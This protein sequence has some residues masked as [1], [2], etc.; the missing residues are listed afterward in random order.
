MSMQF[1][2]LHESGSGTKP[3]ID[4]VCFRC[5]FLEASRTFSRMALKAESDP[6][7]HRDG[8]AERTSWSVTWAYL[9]H[10]GLML[11]ARITLPRFSACSLMSLPKSAGQGQC[12]SSARRAFHVDLV[13]ELVDDL[14]G[15]G[16]RWADAEP[17]ACLVARH[18]FPD[19]RDIGQHLSPPNRR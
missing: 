7:R 2:A 1:V 18:K 4:E 11:A 10:S 8:F 14:E 3:L 9:S 17:D 19:S 6:Q 16:L 5:L 13:V 12:R 15:R